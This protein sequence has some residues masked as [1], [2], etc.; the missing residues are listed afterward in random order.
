[1]P[2]PLRGIPASGQTLLINRRMRRSRQPRGR[3]A[4]ISA[5]RGGPYAGSLPSRAP[6]PRPV[7]LPGR[8]AVRSRGA[9]RGCCASRRGLRLPP[10]PAGNPGRVVGDAGRPEGKVPSR[11]KGGACP[12]PASSERSSRGDLGRVYKG[13]PALGFPARLHSITEELKLPPKPGW[14]IH[15]L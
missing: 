11:C 3:P 4:F 1:M 15:G 10:L 14:A 13:H 2:V 9:A 5:R 8:R 12:P 7:T 6:S